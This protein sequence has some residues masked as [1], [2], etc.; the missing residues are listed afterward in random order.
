MNE[1][2][3]IFEEIEDI[4]LCWQISAQSYANLEISKQLNIYNIWK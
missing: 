2:L 3:R 4:H 1:I